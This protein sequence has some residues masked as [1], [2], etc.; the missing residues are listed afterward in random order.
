MGGSERTGKSQRSRRHSRRI[1]IEPLETRRLLSATG[2]I[3][4]FAYVD[5]ANTGQMASASAGMG[6]L[7]VELLSVDGQGNLN[8]VSGVG[9]TQTLADGSYKFTGLSAGNYEVQIEPSAKLAIGKLTP[10]TA[11][12]TTGTNDIQLSLSDGQAASGN[13]FAITGPQLS[14]LSLRMYLSSTGTPKQFLASM[15]TVPTVATG[16]SA[17]PHFSATFTTGGPAV[18]IAAADATIAA[19]D[20]PTLASMTVTIANPLDGSNEVLAATT[21]GT[22]LTASYSGSTLSISGVAN[23]ATYETVLQSVKY[24]DNLVAG[25]AGNRTIS[26]VVNDG[27]RVS[28]AATSTISVVLGNQNLPIVTTNPTAA[29][30]NAGGT[31]TFTAAASGT[32]TPT[33]QWQVNTGSGFANISDGGV[34]SGS[35]T[36]TLTIT[37]A[38]AAMNTYQY[39]AVFTNSGGTATSN[40]ATL[41]VDF[42]PTVTTSP[43]AQTVNAGSS[44]TFTA[45]AGGNPAAT[46]QW[47]VSTDG[48]QTFSNIAG[49]TSASYSFTTAAA[50]NG[51]QFEAV[52]TNSVGTATSTPATL[53]V[54]FAPTVTTNPTSQV[55][56]D[57][58]T[59][60]FT[61]AAGG[62]PTATVQWKMSSDGGVTFNNVTGA[63]SASYS[64]TAAA[65]ENGEQFEAVFTNSAGTATSSPATLTVNSSTV[66][67]TTNP[68]PQTVNAGATVTFTAAA[69][70]NPTATV[71][72]KVSADGGQTFSNI[73]G[74]TSASYSFT[75]AATD[76]GK[77]FEAVFTDSTGTATST[78]AALTVD[79]APTLTTNPTSQTV[80][81]GGN[82]TFTAAA[83]GNPAAT[84]QWLIEHHRRSQ[85]LHSQSPGA[86]ASYSFTA[87]A[88]DNGNEYEAV[89][90]NSVGAATS[91][92]ATLTVSSALTITTNPTPQTVNAGSTVTLT[93]A[94]SSNPAATVQWEVSTDGGQTFTAISGATSTTYSFTAAAGNNGY[95][96][97]AVFSNS[98]GT[99]TTNPATLTVNFAPTVTTS[100]AS[101]TVNAGGTVTLTAAASSNP[102]AT[103]QWQVNKNDGSGFTNISDGGVYS[104]SS[105]GT[106]TIT[107]ATAD[108]NS[109]VYQAAFT[110][111]VGTSN[112][113]AAVLTVDFAP[114]VTTNPTSQVTT[115]GN[116][117]TFT[118]AASGNPAATV[119]WKMSSDSGLT[120]SDIAGATSATYSFTAAAADDGQQYEA[121]FTNSVGSATTTAATLHIAGY[122]VTA[123]QSLL[124]PSNDT[125]ASFTIGGVSQGDTYS[126]SIASDGGPGTVSGSG[127]VTSSSPSQDVTVDVSS[128]PGGNLTYSV[129]VTHGGSTGNTVTAM[130]VL[131]KTAPTGYTITGLPATIDNTSATNVSFTVNSPAAENGDTFNYTITNPSDNSGNSVTGSGTI[132]ATAQ[133]IT[134]VDVSS[135]ANGTLSFSVTLTDTV[136]NVGAA[137]SATAPLSQFAITS[138][139]ATTATVGDV[140]TYTIQT[141]AASGDTVTVTPGA[142]L[143]AG[144]NFDAGTNTF[145]WTPTADQAG[146]TQSFTASVKDTTTGDSQTLGPV[147]VAVAAANGLT[148][149]APAASIASG[150]PVLVSFR[151][152]NPGTPTYTISTSSAN[153]PTGSNLTATL[154]PQTNQ[155]LKIVTDQGEMDF[156]LFNNFTPNTVQ[157]FDDL[158]NSGAYNTDATFYRIIQSFVDQGGVGGSGTAIPVELNSNLRFTSSGLLAMANNGVDGNSSE[159]FITNPDD[160]SNGF[161][162]FRYTIFGKLISGDNVRA[163]I[164]SVPVTTSS[165]GEDSQP[166]TPPKI[167]SMSVVNQTTGGGVFELQAAPG[168]SGPYTVTISDG[169]GGSQS[170]TV[171]I[172]TD[173]FD[174]PNPWVDPI[175]G[176]DQITT[177]AGTP[178]TFTPQGESADGST[179]QVG[180]Q[181]MLSV[182]SV[183]DAYVDTSFLNTSTAQTNPA[184]NPNPNITVTQNGSSYTVTPAAGFYGVQVLEVTGLNAVSGT[185]QLQVGSTT[186]AAIS[187]DSTN[188]AATATNIQ[189]ALIAAGFGGTTVTVDQSSVAETFSFDVTFA[190]SVG[191]ITYT[192][193]STNPL[194]VTFANTATGPEALQTLTFTATGPAWD[195]GSGVGP[196]YRAFVPVFVDPPAPVL[197][198]IMANGQTVSGSTS[199]NNSSPTAA[200]SFDVTGAVAGALVSVYMDGGTTPIATG[201]VAAGATTITVTTDGATT[202]G[203]GQHTFTVKQSFATSEVDLYADWGANGPSTQ[204]TI[205]ASSVVS[206]PSPGVGLTV[207]T[208]P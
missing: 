73:A 50:D 113:N 96:Y 135:L 136:G 20:S 27:T 36:G 156:Q 86:S 59:V 33:V 52:F 117:V 16:D 1:A 3:S 140:Y 149:V 107:G 207:S 30:I 29:T 75:A 111:S 143:P 97:E 2:S 170:F 192:P 37:G 112:S 31:T 56:S 105:T 196:V 125:I 129:Q 181:T 63:T 80:S 26:V 195:A 13:D 15:H 151:D 49:A 17:A 205:P 168:A 146:T 134:G 183:P 72:W 14:L 21:T 67:I 68:T 43:T 115:A 159:F 103:V 92:P 57:G 182:P 83:S 24:Q 23:I 128:L 198:T 88:G 208:G 161:L 46:V 148:V 152:T 11:G 90:T 78:P 172:G 58:G 186:T 174:P 44:V 120:F 104:G 150:S 39:Q 162:D 138:I 132:T 142:T 122:L 167:L 109:Y 71:Q 157:H 95:Q 187:F 200:L 64:F 25:H 131:D 141:N 53:T 190:S 38:T 91:S 100:P 102:T 165:S 184:Q 180:V 65:A 188:L 193:P 123:D 119:Q 154:L 70:G 118:A 62:N 137:V 6:G 130:T 66:T 139:P 61:A 160:M 55:V 84:V 173:S 206:A 9:P 108:M 7:T 32:P 147:F 82:V 54:N 155:V 197:S 40:A 28:Q 76:N 48:G 18:A 60:T 101:Q 204:F 163:A 189:N 47:Q 77:L 203:D 158:V 145:T 45:A 4:G 99:A 114:T 199:S 106:L 133:S 51:K 81:A 153:D 10:G 201:T 191:N 42:A 85:T 79:F 176:N 5:P 194:P 98:S 121:V 8:G 35:A 178:V 12:G 94:A 34:Y 171:N 22:P 126:Y 179:V 74:A 124:G 177:T 93:A 87:A 202:I 144:M 166:L 127:T 69:S 164:S 116:T 185:Y 175:N 19:S 169:L 89:F 41:K 110:N